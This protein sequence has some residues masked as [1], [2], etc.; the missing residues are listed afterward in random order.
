[1]GAFRI[2]ITGLPNTGKSFAWTKYKHGENV[3]AICPSSKIIHIRTSEGKLIQPL[4]ISIEGIGSNLNEIMQVKKVSNQ[5]DMIAAILGGVEAG[6]IEKNKVKITGNYVTCSDINRVR[7]YKLFVDRMMP[8][9]KIILSPDFTHYISYVIQ[10]RSFMNRK[11]GGEAFQRFW[12]LAA[13]TLNNT[14]LASDDLKNVK[15][16]ITEFH[17]EYNDSLNL[18]TIYT[19]AGK[20]LTEK[21]LPQSYYDIM[22]HTYVKPYEEEKDEA[23]RFKFVVIKRD[24]Y[25][26]RSIGLFSDVSKDGMIDNDMQLVISKMFEYMGE[27]L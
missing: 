8:N 10:T 25:D 24:V 23:K 4:E 13:D 7:M 18:F 5:H 22:L 2:G 3:F 14:I 9:I 1:M 6:Q 19:P 16:D 26:G 11:S 17:S 12:E 27:T 15:L 21:F 20:M